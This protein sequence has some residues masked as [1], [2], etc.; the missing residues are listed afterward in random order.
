M[1]YRYNIFLTF[2]YTE[3]LFEGYWIIITYF[4]I[5]TLETQRY[6]RYGT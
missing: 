2:S 3:M 4:Y 5:D 1:M 6:V